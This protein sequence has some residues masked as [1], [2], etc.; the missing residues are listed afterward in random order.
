[1]KTYT[2]GRGQ[3]TFEN[4]GLY[5]TIGRA[6][7]QTPL[8]GGLYTISAY[9]VPLHIRVEDIRSDAGVVT[10]MA[11]VVSMSR[12]MPSFL[13]EVEPAD[14]LPLFNETVEAIMSGDAESASG[15]LPRSEWGMTEISE[16]MWRYIG[17]TGSVHFVS[18][19][20]A[21]H[22]AGSL[23]PIAVGEVH[24]KV[25]LGSYSFPRPIFSLRA[26]ASGRHYL[27]DGKFV[28]FTNGRSYELVR[29]DSLGGGVLG[30]VQKY[31][32]G[33]RDAMSE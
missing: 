28:N 22:M 30:D 3:I 19:L 8:T 32:Y 31:I 16:G 27:R 25:K 26:G 17:E 20:Y 1:M 23:K 18:N 2:N 7:G 9:S 10:G 21:G 13:Y 4:N 14:F 6:L 15:E 12:L 29:D 5:V 24:E 33:I 11:R